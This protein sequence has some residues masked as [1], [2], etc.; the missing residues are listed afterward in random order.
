MIMKEEVMQ[1]ISA[2]YARPGMT[3]ASPVF[4]NWGDIIIEDRTILGPKDIDKITNTGVGELFITNDYTADLQ[5]RPIIDP[6]LSGAISKALRRF[7]IEIRTTL[8]NKSHHLLDT[9]PLK[10]YTREL[11]SQLSSIDA[12]DISINGCF[13]LKDY[14][15]VHP[16][17]VAAISILIG[18]AEKM[19]EPEL[20]E[21]GM[22]ALFQNIGYALI[23]HG[24][25][26]KAGPLNEIE[27]QIV[28][29]HPVYAQEIL[30]R[31]V[32]IEP[33]IIEIVL[34]HH[35]RWN[36]GGYPGRLKH[37]EILKSAQ[38][39]G[40]TD[41]CFALASKRP[42]REEFLPAFAIEQSIVTPKDAIEFIFAYS[43]ELFN[44]EL[45]RTFTS[46][47]P[48]YPKGVKIKLN[49]GKEGVVCKANSGI[50]RRPQLIIYNKKRKYRLPSLPVEDNGGDKNKTTIETSM[51]WRHLDLSKGNQKRVFVTDTFD[52]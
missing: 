50:V 33:S 16:V 13:S 19:F 17:K 42:H 5:L 40:I 32:E 25:L 38:I 10:E 49:N 51:N 15:F 30:N 47:I 7:I 52:Y 29:K 26:E 12:G 21:M 36:G 3:L 34:Q 8:T 18:I 4:D 41:T 14:N 45:V 23:P 27:L 24:I 46:Q 35:E 43:G 22:A 28:Q 48:V 11:V 39:I 20:V 1:R 9:N 44:P 2:V 31:Y 37:D 6:L